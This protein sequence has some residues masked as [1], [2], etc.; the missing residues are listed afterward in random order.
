MWACQPW[1][2]QVPVWKISIIPCY[3]KWSTIKQFT[4]HNKSISIFMIR[5][6]STHK[7][8]K[9]AHHAGTLVYRNNKENT[10]I[11]YQLTIETINGKRRDDWI[12]IYLPHHATAKLCYLFC[13]ND[14]INKKFHV[15]LYVTIS[16]TIQLCWKLKI[17]DL[18]YSK[19]KK[20]KYSTLIVTTSVHWFF[21]HL[22]FN[23]RTSNF[24]IGIAQCNRWIFAVQNCNLKFEGNKH[25]MMWHK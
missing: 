25:C 18:M 24:S 4:I 22:I 13:R 1:R 17:L 8:R 3:W 12:S 16:F 7:H 11:C 20:A 14:L 5:L 23:W 21:N 6:S 10:H 9:C 19:V 15:L 2:H